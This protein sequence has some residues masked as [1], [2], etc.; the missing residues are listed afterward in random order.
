M[1]ARQILVRPLKVSLRSTN[2]RP[3][4]V[5][6]RNVRASAVAA[7]PPARMAMAWRGH[8]RAASSRPIAVS[9]TT[10]TNSD[11]RDC[12]GRISAPHRS[13]TPTATPR[14]R[15]PIA[16]AAAAAIPSAILRP[17]KFLL[18]HEAAQLATPRDAEGRPAQRDDD[19]GQ[20]HRGDRRGDELGLEARRK[21]RGERDA[22]G[23]GAEQ[24][25]APQQCRARHVRPG[26]GH[27]CQ[28]ERRP[29][30]PGRSDILG[31]TAEIPGEQQG[32]CHEDGEQQRARHRHA[33]QQLGKATEPAVEQRVEGIAEDQDPRQREQAVAP[34]GALRMAGVDGAGRDRCAHWAPRPGRADASQRRTCTSLRL[35]TQA[36]I[37]APPQGTKARSICMAAAPLSGK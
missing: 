36:R 29:Q 34:A 31:G 17:S 12:D 20:G 8:V 18:Q 2:I 23:A 26:G 11:A 21:A 19:A 13:S 5:A 1:T 27:A 16:A 37:N 7:A 28:H 30:G 10:A 15:P 22:E 6:S 9:T 4:L 3:V 35:R 14:C 33:G 25:G 24:G 32:A